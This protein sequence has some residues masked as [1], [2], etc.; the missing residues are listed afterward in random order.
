[1][2]NFQERIS[3]VRHTLR[4]NRI[5]QADLAER[6]GINPAR[7]SLILN[8]H[9]PTMVE[10]LKLLLHSGHHVKKVFPEIESDMKD[11]VNLLESGDSENALVSLI[12]LLDLTPHYETSKNTKAAS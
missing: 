5:K 9:Q 6:M 11:I 3:T 8:G 2:I 7:V 1:M 10:L 4:E 12:N